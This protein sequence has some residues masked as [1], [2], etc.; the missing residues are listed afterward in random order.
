MVWKVAGSFEEA[1]SI[2]R[3]PEVCQDESGDGCR[4]AII[5]SGICKGLP[6]SDYVNL[7][8]R[9]IIDTDGHGSIMHAIISRILPEAEIYMVKVPDPLP[10]NLLIT[11]LKEAV[12]FNPH[13]VNLSI[14]SEI[15]SDGSD[16]SSI[17]INHLSGRTLVAVAAGNGGPRLLSIGSPAVAEMALTVGAADL[18]GRLWKRSSRGPTLDGRWK[19]NIVAPTGFIPPDHTAEALGTSFSTPFATALGAILV[20]RL[21]DPYLAMKIMELTATPIPISTSVNPLLAGMRRAAAVR[22]LIEAWPRLTDPR[23]MAGM[24]LVNASEAVDVAQRMLKGLTDISR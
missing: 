7:T 21:H 18:R 10:D 15:P 19:P 5:D 24:G 2:A 13:S 3:F 4:I 1:L 16:P 14:T 22:R 17:Y 23:N 12:K 20:K 9:S 11:A 6:V 8:D